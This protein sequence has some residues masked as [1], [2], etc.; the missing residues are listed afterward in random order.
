MRLFVPYKRRKKENELPTAPGKK[1]AAKNITLLPATAATTCELSTGSPP[2]AHTA[3]P[4][5][6]VPTA[7]VRAWLQGLGRE[8][9]P[10]PLP[11]CPHLWTG[12][13]VSPQ[14]PGVPGFPRVPAVCSVPT[15]GPGLLGSS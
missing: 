4:T 5:A 3:V 11:P 7:P 14:A 12:L 9:P 15:L 6:S 8:H 2:H 13:A 1:E 10:A